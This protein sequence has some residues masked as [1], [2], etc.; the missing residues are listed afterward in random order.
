MK[1]ITKSKYTLKYDYYITEEGKV[2]STKTQKFLSTNLDK[3][4]YIKVSLCSV[5][6]PPGKRHSYSVHRLVL[7]NYRPTDNM[8][9]M[10][11][12]H[13][14]GDKTNNNINNLEWVTV[15]QNIKHAVNNNLRAKINGSAKLTKD[16]VIQIYIASHQGE[17]NVSLAQ[18][19]NIHPDSVGRIK[20]KRLWKKVIDD[21]LKTF[22]DY[23]ESE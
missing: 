7:E 23:R 9:L 10:Q 11:V 5:D 15:A 17:S 3:D 13:I 1:L 12:N 4:G 14:D 8:S 21:Y 6:L 16:Q 2:W 22:N 19:Y 20:N 18:K